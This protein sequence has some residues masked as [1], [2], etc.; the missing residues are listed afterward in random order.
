MSFSEDFQRRLRAIAGRSDQDVEM[1]IF[2]EIDKGFGGCHTCGYGGEEDRVEY[3]V[4]PRLDDYIY[5]GV[6]FTSMPELLAALDA[7]PDA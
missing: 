7:V 1:V 5:G 6:R 4:A 2:S 3:Y